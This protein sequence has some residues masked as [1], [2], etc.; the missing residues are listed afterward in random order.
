VNKKGKILDSDGEVIG[1]LID[2]EASKCAGKKVN[3]RGEVMDGEKVIG[4]VK[5]V[6]GDAANEAMKELEQQLGGVPEADEEEEEQQEGEEPGEEAIDDGLPPLSILDG[7]KCNKAGKILNDK[8]EIVGEL[9]EGDAK[10]LSRS[11]AACDEEGRFWDSKGRVIGRAK[12][13]ERQDEEEDGAFAGLEGLVVVKD[14]LVEDENHNVVG[15]IIEGDAK[16]LIGRTLDEDGDILDKKGSVIGRA[17]RYEVPE[18]EQQ[19]PADLSALDGTTINKRGFAVSPEGRVIGQVVEGDAKKL[20]GCKVDG[21]G[22]IWSASGK[23]LGRCELVEDHDSSS[24]GPFGG[25]PDNKVAKDG[26]VVSGDTVIGRVIEG[27]VKRLAGY[28]VDADGEITDK[29][30]NVIGKA[31][32]WEPEEKERKKSPMSGFKINKEGEVRGADGEVLGRLTSGDLGQC[33]GLEVDD[34]GNVVDQ[35]GN[36]VGAATLLENIHEEEAEEV[37]ED[38]E[39]RKEIAVKMSDICQ[40]TLERIQPVMKQIQEASLPG[41]LQPRR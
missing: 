15:R 32:R 28:S 4:R 10:K 29:N 2:G 27:D 6:P 26:T 7:L 19:A 9:V 35:D 18:E 37:D 41:N 24:D 33:I 23:V 25:F 12:T 34:N 13:V 20:V 11:G 21:K 36:I 1:E 22:Q 40:Q 16:K 30:G 38:E 31:E 39:Q 5:V 3:A 17:E 8:G 14:G